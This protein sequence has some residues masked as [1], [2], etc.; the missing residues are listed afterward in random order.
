[1]QRITSAERK[2]LG[3]PP[4]WTNVEICKNKKEKVHVRGIDNKGRYQYIYRKEW[5]DKA[6]KTKFIRIK[7]FIKKIPYIKRLFLY[8]ENSSDNKKKLICLI[9]RLLLCSY[10]R[11]GNESY[12]KENKTYGLC[13]MKKNHCRIKEND[14]YF[15]FIGKKGKCQNIIIKSRREIVKKIKKLR[16]IPGEYLFQYIENGNI[17]KIN[18][19]EVNQFIYDKIGKYTCKDFRTYGANKEIYDFLRK[20]E[21]PKNKT[22]VNKNLSDAMN[23]VSNKLGNTKT[24]CKKSYISKKLIEKYDINTNFN[25]MKLINII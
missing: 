12:E 16:R 8:N 15:N 23:H 18:A 6:S 19:Y 9:I 11:I 7:K 1:M 25:R 5:N 4:A 24:I 14:I 20:R 10:I 17:R 22:D 3:V 21:I 2:K 13:T